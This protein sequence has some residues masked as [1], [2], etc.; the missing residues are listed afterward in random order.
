MAKVPSIETHTYTEHSDD[1]NHD[2][3]CHC[4]GKGKV[5][6]RTGHEDLEGECRYTSTLSLTSALDGVGGQHY[7]PAALPPGK[8]APRPVWMGAKNFAPPGF[9]PLK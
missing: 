9:D 6:P 7:A 5:L 3:S 2:I 1:D 8:R 4:K